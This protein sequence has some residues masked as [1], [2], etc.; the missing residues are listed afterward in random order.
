MESTEKILGTLRA[1]FLAAPINAEVLGIWKESPSMT[2]P[3]RHSDQYDQLM[4]CRKFPKRNI[5]RLSSP[6]TSQD[7]DLNDWIIGVEVITQRQIAE[8]IARGRDEVS[9]RDILKVN[10][11]KNVQEI[12]RKCEAKGADSAAVLLE[13]KTESLR[14]A[15]CNVMLRSGLAS[16]YARCRRAL[17]ER[18]NMMRCTRVRLLKKVRNISRVEMH[19]MEWIRDVAT[20][21]QDVDFRR[22]SWAE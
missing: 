2:W 10:T 3:Y 9:A 18:E 13:F 19:L 22:G 11:N 7:T 16:T 15:F 4:A 14:E 1:S 21:P 6:D 8:L 12:L 5:P 17:H 20:L